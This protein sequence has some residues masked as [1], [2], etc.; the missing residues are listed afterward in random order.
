MVDFVTYKPLK[1]N[2]DKDKYPEL[3]DTLSTFDY[4]FLKMYPKQEIKEES[5]KIEVDKK[6]EKLDTIVKQK[7]PTPTKNASAPVKQTLK[8]FND[9]GFG[10]SAYGFVGNFLH[11]SGLNP[12]AINKGEAKRTQSYGAGIYQASNE[13]KFNWERKNGGRKFETASLDEQLNYALEEARAR[14]AF[15]SAMKQIDENY[16]AGRITKEDAIKQATS[17]VLLGFENGG[18][19]SMITPTKFNL[20]YL[21][22]PLNGRSYEQH[23]ATR[24]K[25]ALGAL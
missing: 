20:I 8:F 10:I 11:E 17:A 1:P 23:L 12:K 13:R 22:N 3:N 6:E 5:P 4:P 7:N 16:N 19:N 14:P 25:L 2:V 24:T 15:M 21:K 9:N 18:T